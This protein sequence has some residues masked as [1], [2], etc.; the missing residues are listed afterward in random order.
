M[1][2]SVHAEISQHKTFESARKKI[3]KRNR[4][5]GQVAFTLSSLF[6]SSNEIKHL[7]SFFSHFFAN[8]MAISSTSSGQIRTFHYSKSLFNL[9]IKFMY[10]SDA[11]T[12]I[13]LL[14]FVFLHHPVSNM[15][16]EQSCCAHG[17]DSK[18]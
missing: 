3:K 10:I 18:R 5:E 7:C 4:E 14:K 1:K 17:P 6:K 2:Q 12:F 8:K 13:S 16:N 15:T 9:I 11:H